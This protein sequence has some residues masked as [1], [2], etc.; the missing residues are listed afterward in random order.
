VRYLI[1]KDLECKYSTK[2]L[3]YENKNNKNNK[4]NNNKIILWE[5]DK[6]FSLNNKKMLKKNERNMIQISN[7]NKSIIIGL[8][9]SEGHI[10]KRKNWN[11]RIQI[12]Q[13]IKNFE[14][15]WYVFNKFNIFNS[16]YPFLTKR[17]FR[18]KKFYT[19]VFKTRQ[20]NC[21]NEYHNLFYHYNKKIIRTDLFF[22]FDYISLA[23]WIMG[24][25]SKRGKGL[26]LCTDSYSIT[27]VI[28]LINILKIKFDLDSSIRYH[29]SLLPNNIIKKVPRIYIDKNNLD[30]IK[31]YIKH[32][33]IESMLYKIN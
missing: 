14:Y 17:T 7:F 25:G 28:I 19:L 15:L 6:D 22:Y 21:F 2:V 24:D 18:N 31:P 12:E 4:N 20:L 29:T 8:I 23:H 26:I 11:A 3:S 13:S 27:E 5:T 30:K 16:N 32:Y 10:E 9:L 1:I 33:F